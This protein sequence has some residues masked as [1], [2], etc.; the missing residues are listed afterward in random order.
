MPIV[1]AGALVSTLPSRVIAPALDT[2]T[3]PPLPLVLPPFAAISPETVVVP[4]LS[5]TTLPPSPVALALARTLAPASTVTVCA[6]IV[7]VTPVP[8]LARARVVPSATVPPPASPE[9]ET[10]PP[11]ATFTAR[12][13]A[14]STSPPFVPG[15]A[16]RAP[17]SPSTVIEPPMPAIRSVPV[18][19]PTELACSLPPAETRVCTIPSAARAVSVILPPSATIVPELVTSA[20]TFF[21]SGPMGACVTWP[22][23]S[24]DTSLSP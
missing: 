3:K 20:V 21:P 8:P 1:P 12:V 22:V 11:D 5:A 9:T 18:W 13:A 24:I 23:T 2:S 16:P 15:A 19:S 4:L 7:G 10:R 14:S 6:V 17:T